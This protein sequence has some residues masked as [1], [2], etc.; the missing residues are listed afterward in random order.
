MNP[1]VSPPRLTSLQRPDFFLPSNRLPTEKMVCRRRIMFL[2]ISSSSLVSEVMSGSIRPVVRFGTRNRS[3]ISV[4]VSIRPDHENRW[5]RLPG[6]DNRVR[7][8]RETTVVRLQTAPRDSS[9]SDFRG[10]RTQVKFDQ[11]TSYRLP[12]RVQTGLD[13]T[14]GLRWIRLQNGSLDH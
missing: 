12:R 11:Q 4:L 8:G 5:I 6:D 2:N 13:S 3:L 1:L 10:G 9:E 7:L 14:E